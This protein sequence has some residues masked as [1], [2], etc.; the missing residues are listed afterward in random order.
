MDCDADKK[1][2][3]LDCIF[4]KTSIAVCLQN[5]N[6]FRVYNNTLFV[7]NFKS[8][9]NHRLFFLEV[10]FILVVLE[11]TLNIAFKTTSREE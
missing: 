11:L 6:S 8:P 10:V 4:S 9:Q 1:Q 5:C 7:K 3:W 2:F